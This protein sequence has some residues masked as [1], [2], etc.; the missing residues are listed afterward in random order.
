MV[1]K[2]VVGSVGNDIHTVAIRLLQIELE[3]RGYQVVYLGVNREP[4]DFV[5]DA[6]SADASAVLVSTTNGEA[7]VWCKSIPRLFLEAR[8]VDVILVLGGNLGLGDYDD[9]LVEQS[10]I[11]AGFDFVFSRRGRP[12]EVVDLIDKELKNGS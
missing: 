6:L 8:L 4:H 5:N 9:A 11:D 3:A 12:V 2:I 1:K 10:Y 7:A